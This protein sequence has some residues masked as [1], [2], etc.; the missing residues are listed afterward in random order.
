MLLFD[1]LSVDLSVPSVHLFF[2]L[3]RLLRLPI[4]IELLGIVMLSLVKELLITVKR[5]KLE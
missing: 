5:R 1:A 4:V 2:C 3:I